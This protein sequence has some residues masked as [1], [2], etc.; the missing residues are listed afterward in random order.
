MNS[1]KAYLKY[2][3]LLEEK[4]KAKSVKYR[5]SQYLLRNEK[6]YMRAISTPLLLNE[7]VVATTVKEVHMGIFTNQSGR[8]FLAH[9][10]LRQGYYWPTMQS[11][12]QEFVKKC[13]KWQCFTS[14]PR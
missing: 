2:A 3:T 6:L 14:Y 12:A 1:L 7:E 11:D 4:E 9:K 5:L 13:E 8:K 10:L